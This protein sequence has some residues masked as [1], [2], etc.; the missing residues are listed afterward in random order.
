MKHFS[1]Y[2]FLSVITV[3]VAT[4]L[5]IPAW[6][7]MPQRQAKPVISI[8]GDSY[9]TFQG[10]IPEDN[11]SWY[12]TLPD[13]SRTDVDDVTQTWW[14]QLISEGGYILG[15]NDSYSGATVC[16]TGYRGED[17]SDRS[18]I[19]RLPC[20]GSPDILLI[21]GATNDSWARVPMGEFVYKNL[22][23][24]HYYEFRPALGQLL[25]GAKK[26]YP[27]TDVYFILNDGL[28]EAVADAVMKECKHF[29]IPVI[30]LSDIDKKAGHPTRRGMIQI[31]EQVLN[32]LQAKSM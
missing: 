29:D 25:D 7:G 21:F 3:F 2:P 18:F 23:R 27:G 1:K 24:G 26:M 31:K 10:Y 8:L 9:S 6:A 15:K 20:L 30:V 22:T 28:S 4:L 16:Y 17:Y 32:A 14:W 13:R 19:T 11:L 12:S 5:T